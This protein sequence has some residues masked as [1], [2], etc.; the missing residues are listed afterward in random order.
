MEAS[1]GLRCSG[2]KGARA[3]RVE[4]A[5]GSR[6]VYWAFRSLSPNIKLELREPI[7]LESHKLVHSKVKTSS[8]VYQLLKLASKRA[9]DSGP[10]QSFY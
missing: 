6:P 5:A 10:C 8:G 7:K 9:H 3:P 2:I 1:E 4:S